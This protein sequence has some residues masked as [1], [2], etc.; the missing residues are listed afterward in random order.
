MLMNLI[1]A[2]LNSIGPTP[3]G[4]GFDRFS[5]RWPKF[6]GCCCAAVMSTMLLAG[7]LSLLDQRHGSGTA[8]EWAVP[9]L[10]SILIWF[11]AGQA[12]LYYTLTFAPWSAQYLRVWW[13]ATGAQDSSQDQ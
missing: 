12:W 11:F 9:A 7:A 13:R 6:L 2:A 10:L 1:R 5:N 8:I 4:P 3:E